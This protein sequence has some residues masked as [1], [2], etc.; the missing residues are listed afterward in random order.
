MVGWALKS[1]GHLWILHADS[2]IDYLV[3]QLGSRRDRNKD[4]LLFI[5]LFVVLRWSYKA[6]LTEWFGNCCVDQAGLKRIK[7]YLP[8]PPAYWN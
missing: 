1:K 4:I 2:D 7:I 3:T 5:N 6:P 8:L